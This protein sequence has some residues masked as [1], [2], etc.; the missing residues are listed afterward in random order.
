MAWKLQLL[1]SGNSQVYEPPSTTTLNAPSPLMNPLN[2]LFA[3]AASPLATPFTVLSLAPPATQRCLAARDNSKPSGDSPIVHDKL[4][5]VYTFNTTSIPMFFNP[6]TYAPF[7]SQQPENIL[8]RQLDRVNA[9]SE[10]TAASL[11]EVVSD[12]KQLA[13]GF[14]EGHHN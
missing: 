1:V 5:Y 14:L 6:R 8:Q 11:K 12:V 2:Q 4:Q 3:A 9:Q 7:S 13:H 10:A